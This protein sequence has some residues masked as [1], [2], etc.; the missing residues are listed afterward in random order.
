[1]RPLHSNENISPALHGK[2]GASDP[3]DLQMITI[4]ASAGLTR[5]S[6]HRVQ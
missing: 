4:G 5:T 1:M 6:I 3:A 2:G